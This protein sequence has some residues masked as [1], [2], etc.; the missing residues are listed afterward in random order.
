V[1]YEW[2]VANRLG[3]EIEVPVVFTQPLFG[4]EPDSLPKSRIE[5]LKT[6]VQWSF[7]VNEKYKTT[8]ALGYINEVLLEGFSDLSQKFLKG[9]KFNPFFVAAKRFGNRFHTLLYTGPELTYLFN[10]KKWKTNYD[11]NTS[12]HYMIHGS[13]NFIGLEVNKTI[14]DGKFSMML[15]PQMRVAVADNFL[16]GIVT[17]IPTNENQRFS[18]FLRVIYEPGHMHHK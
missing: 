9:N 15:R 8:L 12:F 10:E 16:V 2:A 7:L 13:R 6:A 17:G 4:K 18:T 1:E 5:G 11:I 14:E 3:L